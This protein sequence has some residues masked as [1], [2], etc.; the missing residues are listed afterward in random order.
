MSAGNFLTNQQ[1]NPNVGLNSQNY[2]T[3]YQMQ[4]LPN[5]YFPQQFGTNSQQ[6]SNFNFS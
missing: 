1:I 5:Q 3:N 6:M 2:A 4:Y